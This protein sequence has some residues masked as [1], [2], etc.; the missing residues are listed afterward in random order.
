MFI[1]ATL[2]AAQTWAL[3][4]GIESPRGSVHVKVV[5][6]AILK[7]EL[8][9][10]PIMVHQAD[11]ERGFVDV[12]G[13][14]LLTVTAKGMKPTVTLDFAPGTGPFKSVDVRVASNRPPA[15][16]GPSGSLAPA[17][18]PSHLVSGRQVA[19]LKFRLNLAESARPGRSD[20][21]MTLTVSL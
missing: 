5:P 4:Q 21:P 2:L 19:A 11:I 16:T 9:S 8:A 12:P 15:G 3:A 18:S 1:L 20:V 10:S 7:F 14:S 17:T 13:S 6:S